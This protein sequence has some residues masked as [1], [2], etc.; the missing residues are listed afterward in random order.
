[1]RVAL[2]ATSL[3]LASGGL[4]RYTR[5][6]SLALAVRPALRHARGGAA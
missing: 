3:T 5:E 1:M 2:E 4:A 6:L